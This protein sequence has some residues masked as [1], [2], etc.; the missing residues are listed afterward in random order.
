MIFRLLFCKVQKTGKKEIPEQSLNFFL[1]RRVCKLAKNFS[2]M[3]YN[4]TNVDLFCL[5]PGSR[6]EIT[7]CSVVTCKLKIPMHCMCPFWIDSRNSIYYTFRI[8]HVPFKGRLCCDRNPPEKSFWRWNNFCLFVV[9][10]RFMLMG[11]K[12]L[13]VKVLSKCYLIN[14]SDS[15]MVFRLFPH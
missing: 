1:P 6:P 7:I 8:G 12:P 11:L 2:V 9:G 14:V 15:G 5:E 13:K 4:S 3:V 10:T